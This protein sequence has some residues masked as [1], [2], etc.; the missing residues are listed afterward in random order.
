MN[1]D[2]TVSPRVV[3]TDTHRSIENPS[4]DALHDLLADM[5][6]SVPFVIVDRFD[7]SEPGD[8]FIQVHLDEAVDP[9][10]G[11]GYIVEFRDGGPD[12][13]FR[14]TVSDTTPWDAISSPA[15]D[16]VVNVIQDWAFGRGGWRTALSWEPLDFDA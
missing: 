2:K 13:H 15:F 6:L 14:A 4:E 11:H 16:T 9:Q 3:A 8:H 12:A 5:N 7:S 10:R 1:H